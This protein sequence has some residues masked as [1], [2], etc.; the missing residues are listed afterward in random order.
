MKTSDMTTEIAALRQS[1]LGSII[2]I[3][4]I[5]YFI[6]QIFVA[7]TWSKPY[8]VLYNTISD[9]GNTMCGTY[10][11]SLVCSPSHEW[12]N[13]SFVVLGLS[14]SIGSLLMYRQ[15]T[16]IGSAVGFGCMSLAGLGTMLVGLFPEN[17]VST[18]HILGAG[19]TFVMGNLALV[20]LGYALPMPRILRYCTITA[21]FIALLALLLFLTHSYLGLGIGGMERITAYPQ[22][23]WL[24]IFGTYTLRRRL[25]LQD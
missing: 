19:L 22:T 2:W 21:G 13:L 17:T 18:L 5:Q 16:S 6:T 24:I 11:S 4:S 9:L 3:V 14:T 25:K 20:L 23:I 10:R 8:S 7:L 1:L 12:M 15:R